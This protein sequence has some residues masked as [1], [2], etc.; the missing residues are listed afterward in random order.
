MTKSLQFSGFFFFFFFFFGFFTIEKNFSL[1]FYY[2]FHIVV[3]YENE[4]LNFK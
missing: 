1:W 4:F 3:V 2:I